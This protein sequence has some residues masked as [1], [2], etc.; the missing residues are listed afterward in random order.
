MG[1]VSIDWGNGLPLIFWSNADLFSVAH[2]GTHFSETS[3]KIHKFSFIEMHLEIINHNIQTS[4]CPLYTV[5]RH[6]SL[7]EVE[8]CIFASANDAVIGSDNGLSPGWRQAIIWQN[9]EIL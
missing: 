5:P 1:Q 7:I 8:W 4:F 6:S 9:T 3:I 2:S